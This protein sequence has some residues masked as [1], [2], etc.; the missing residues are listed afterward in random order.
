M[1]QNCFE[2]GSKSLSHY[3]HESYESVEYEEGIVR[4]TILVALL[5]V[6]VPLSGSAAAAR[7]TIRDLGPNVI[8]EG[9]NNLGQIA[10]EVVDDNGSLLRAIL[11]D[12]PFVTEISHPSDWRTGP[13]FTGL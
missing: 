3:N 13:S 9:I 6:T 4:N 10:A 1:L 7:Y 12:G 5:L 8:P 11:I 2:V